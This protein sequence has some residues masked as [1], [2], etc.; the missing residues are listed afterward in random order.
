M[1]ARRVLDE[2]AAA[3]A[4]K[5]GQDLRALDLAELLGLTDYFLLL[6]ATSERQ[7]STILDEVERRVREIGRRPDRREGTADSGWVVID[8]GDVVVHAFLEEQRGFY[9]LERLWA[10]AP[11]VPLA[12][13]ASAR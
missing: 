7:L 11:D 10:D 6:S 13:S 4:A 1:P 3:A 9:A 8:Y 2:A 5:Q 12:V